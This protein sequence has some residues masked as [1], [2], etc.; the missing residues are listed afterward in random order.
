[1][2]PKK[3]LKRSTLSS[4]LK[5]LAII[6]CLFINQ[7]LFAQDP[8][9]PTGLFITQNN[10]AFTLTWNNDPLATLYNVY[11]SENNGNAYYI[12]TLPVGTTSYTYSGT[13]GNINVTN[14]GNYTA[15]VQAIPDDNNNAY[16]HSNNFTLNAIDPNPPTELSVSHSNNAFT[17]SWNNDPLATLYNV[18]ISENGGNAYYIA[19]LPAG[20]NSY[21]YSGTY[22]NIN[23]VNGGN[24]T[25][26]V[27]AIPDSNSNA[28]AHTEAFVLNTVVDPNSPSGLF[29]SQNNDAFT[30]TWN[31]DP[32]ATYYN[33]YISENGGNAYYITTIPAETNSYTYSGTYGNINITNGGNYTATVQAI[34][35]DN[36]NAY[37]NSEQFI[38]TPN[39][40]SIDPNFHIYL[41]FGQSNMEGSANIET[42][43]RATNTRFKTLQSLDCP[44]LNKNK[45]TWYTSSPPSSQCYSKLSLVN[46][47]GKNMV[48][49]SESNVTI[50]VINVAVGGSDI[51][52][53]DKD[54]YQD[55]DTTINQ[56][57]FFDKIAAY[58]GNPYQH[59]I[60]L[61]KI[62]QQTGVIKGILLH[63]GESNADKPDT[64][65]W[66]QYVQK[67]YNDML[68][69]L[70]LSASDV[71]LLAGEVAHS[72][73][74]GLLGNM[75]NT[76]NTLPNIV[77]SA[78]I[79]SSDGC[80]IQNDNI[81]FN[82][83]GVREL[84]L[85][86]A[87]KM[88]TLQGNIAPITNKANKQYL[89]HSF[90]NT[91]EGTTLFNFEIDKASNVSIKLF[92]IHGQQ[93]DIVTQH[94]YPKG[95]HTVEY[96]SKKLPKGLYLYTV[97]TDDTLIKQKIVISE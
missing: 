46:S 53:F 22:G 71:P 18:F 69:D 41:A 40:N 48:T 60:N 87:T 58:G 52:L 42:I 54:I 63:Q 1:M 73:N 78:H 81:H 5:T 7:N 24:Y 4:F 26:T 17:L 50:G 36:N 12:T 32:L 31:N 11:I 88:L 2:K 28:Y 62:A 96:N 76:I 10:N 97:K 83:A 45:N 67:I 79:I 25:A 43:D 68:T 95:K 77:P 90:Q 93:I 34:P 29:V 37:A 38:L 23:I 59:L 44:N 61:A 47:F 82:S 56:Q 94:Y 3:K 85:R 92:N 33:I 6:S 66:P 27:Q 65:Q 8:E 89:N 30:L 75:N 91:T 80:A 35:D 70:S 14:G 74:G 20:T 21:T 72:N 86:F 84:G 19:T 49:N 39:N 55:Y 16:A 64:A 9:T 57:W 13:Y 51:R 15:T